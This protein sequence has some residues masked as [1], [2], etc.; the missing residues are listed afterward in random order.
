MKTIIISIVSLF[1][2]NSPNPVK[3]NYCNKEIGGPVSIKTNP[4]FKH[5]LRNLQELVNK[6]GTQQ[7]NHFYIAKYRQ[8]EAFTYMIWREGRK[9]WILSIGGEEADHWFWVIQRPRGGSCVDL[10]K[11]VV[12]TPEEISG[13]TYLVDQPWVNEKLFECVISGD[14]IVI[15]KSEK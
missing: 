12:P 7:I 1:F 13:S 6:E 9:L 8:N 4:G 15:N 11:D 3:F 5:V 2:L 14:L 10:D